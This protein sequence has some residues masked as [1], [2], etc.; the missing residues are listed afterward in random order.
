MINAKEQL[1]S[2]RL[3][4]G[5]FTRKECDEETSKKYKEIVTKEKS[6]EKLPNNVKCVMS[7]GTYR[8]FYLD[9]KMTENEIYEFIGYK[10]I[11]LLS[12]I[13][14]CIMFFT[15]CGIVALV[16]YV[17]YIIYLIF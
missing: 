1:N 17:F 7:M 12:T 15:I 9:S 11:T 3:M 4:Y 16:L 6:Y 8:F 10:I 13:K 2:L 14:N 5:T